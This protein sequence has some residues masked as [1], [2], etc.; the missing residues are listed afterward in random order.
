MRIRFHRQ[1]GSALLITLLSSVIIGLSL[2]AYLEIVR[3]QNISTLRSLQWNLAIP[4]AEAGIEEALTHLYHN[5]TNRL[6]DGWV[7]QSGV[8]MKERTMGESKYVTTI[9]DTSQPVIIS[10]GYVR[11][12]LGTEFIDPP[13][14]IRVTTTNDALFAKGMV[15]KGQIDLSGN[16]VRTDSFDSTDPDHSTDGHYDPTKAKDNGDVATNSSVVDSLNVWNAEIFGKASTGPGGT[17]SVGPNGSIGSSAWHE[18]GKKGIEPGYAT[19]D[20]NVYFPD[21]KPPFSGGG[22]IPLS[23][24]Y[25]GTNY[26]YLITSGNWT[27]SSL[28]LSGQDKMLVLGNAVVYVTGDVSVSGQAYVH[29]ATNSSLQLFVAGANTAIGGNGILNTPGNATNFFYYGL[30]TNTKLTMSGNASFTGAIYAPQAT[31]SLGGGGSAS[32]DFVGASVTKTV[33]MNGHYNFHFISRSMTSP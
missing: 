24:T 8:H 15:A 18:A 11:V 7:L 3:N 21:V 28:N 9:S 22:F 20:M 31:F 30:P 26:N 23:G 32:Y 4:V 14:T 1:N 25:G 10:K 16:R 29:V 19:D 2:A 17:V 12:P 6:N 33:K 27:M 13:R 5:P